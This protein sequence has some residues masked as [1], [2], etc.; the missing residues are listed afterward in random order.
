MT[1]LSSDHHLYH[2]Y[3]L[4]RR[5]DH[6]HRS[7]HH[8]SISSSAGRL[9]EISPLPRKQSEVRFYDVSDPLDPKRLGSFIDRPGQSAGAV[10]IV[11]QQNGKWLALVGDGDNNNIDPW[12]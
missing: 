4:H 8:T 2:L 9:Q 1:I 6:H 10:G 3:H 5:R 7:L 11:Q 12:E